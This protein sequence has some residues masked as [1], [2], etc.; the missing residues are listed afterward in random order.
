VAGRKLREFQDDR[1][2]QALALI[3]RMDHDVAQIRAIEAIGDGAARADQYAT[4]EDEAPNMLLAKTR[5]RCSGDLAPNGAIRYSRDTSI[6]SMELCSYNQC[7]FIPAAELVSITLLKGASLGLADRSQPRQ[8]LRP[9]SASGLDIKRRSIVV[10]K[11][12]PHFRIDHELVLP[13]S[14][15]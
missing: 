15:L 10:R 9:G 4:V 3:A 5:C 14:C 8:S 12:V 1:L 7:T 13:M 6:Q 11:S 2:S